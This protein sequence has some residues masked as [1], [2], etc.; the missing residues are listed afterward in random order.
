MT[1]VYGLSSY[2]NLWQIHRVY[3]YACISYLLYYT[4]WKNERI[5][6]HSHHA[7]YTIPNV[8][9]KI[10]VLTYW[11]AHLI[12]EN[13]HVISRCCFPVSQIARFMGPT[14][15]PPGSCRPQMGHMLAPWTLPSGLLKLNLAVKQTI[16]CSG[17]GVT[18]AF[19]HSDWHDVIMTLTHS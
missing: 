16:F 6:K 7:L 4:S 5:I 2:I 14:W 18:R 11:Y 1:S 12:P 8:S 13:N 9:I 19:G 15:G 3:I 17:Y 10:V